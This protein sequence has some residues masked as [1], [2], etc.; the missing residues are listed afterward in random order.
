MERGLSI[1]LLLASGF[2][3]VASADG[4]QEANASLLAEIGRIRAIDNHSHGTPASPPGDEPHDPIGK[5]PFPYPLRLRVDS[6][7]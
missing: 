2:V 6:P 7:E 1:A 4:Q 3:F 5:S